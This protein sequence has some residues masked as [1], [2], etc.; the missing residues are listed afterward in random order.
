MSESNPARYYL[1]L[2]SG[3]SFDG[4][5]AALVDE[6]GKQLLGKYWLKMPAA[7]QRKIRAITLPGTNEINRQMEINHL[8]ADFYATAVKQLLDNRDISSEQLIAIGCHGQTVRHS[9]DT[10][11]SFSLQLGC[12]FR[13]AMR[14]RVTVVNQF[15]QAD[16]CV[17]GQGAPLAPLYHK[18]LF[19]RQGEPVAV[20]NIGGIANV[21]HVDAEGRV[22]GFDTGPGNCLLDEWVERHLGVP[23]DQNGEWARGGRVI[24]GLLNELMTGAF[25]QQ[26][27]PKSLDRA[28]Y[29]LNRLSQ[30]FEHESPQDVQAS[31]TH[32]VAR[33]IADAIKQNHYDC[34]ALLV[35]G[36]G[37]HNASLMQSLQQLLAPMK[38]VS[39]A[40]RG[41]DPDF[42]EAMM[43]A[44][45]ASQT[46]SRT[47]LKTSTV[48]GAKRP[49]ILGSIVYSA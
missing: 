42:L 10:Q 8:L 13:L 15:R 36:G 41:V 22:T 43:M 1:G 12:P 38:V 47:R 21:T 9:S 25:I 2:M 26:K 23:Y 34:D 18:H 39:T 49:V 27:P 30:W 37:V 48:T 14:T 7:L 28:C 40:Q 4:V 24:L 5:D 35:C 3:T 20:V 17:G 11:I 46:L 32:F 16:M 29:Q 44:W 33:H 31:L 45:L 19:Y 6:T